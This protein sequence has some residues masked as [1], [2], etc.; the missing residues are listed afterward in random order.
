MGDFHYRLKDLHDSPSVPPTRDPRT[1][2][3]RKLTPD[4][5]RALYPGTPVATGPDRR[6]PLRDRLREIR[7]RGARQAPFEDRKIQALMASPLPK[8]SLGAPWRSSAGALRD[9]AAKVCK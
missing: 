5:I 4:E 8:V 6:P 1:G 2:P 7:A 3:G 9:A